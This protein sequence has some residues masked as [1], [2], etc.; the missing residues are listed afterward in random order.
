MMR[1][2]LL[3]LTLAGLASTAAA[4][5]PLDPHAGHVMEQPAKPVQAS[6][7]PHA[8][9]VMP[10][11]Q[12]AHAE[13]A[14]AASADPHAGHRAPPPSAPADPHAGHIMPTQSAAP[15]DPH[16][17]H[18]MPALPPAPVDPH[19]GHAMSPPSPARTGVDLPI[20]NGAPPPVIVDNLADQT[21]GS[22][23]MQRARATLE[24]EH[25]GSPISKVQADLLE[26][27]PDGERYGWEVE[28]W[29]GG[30]INRLAIKTEG[31]G[32]SREGVEGAEVQLLYSRAVSRYTDVQ[33]GLRY[34][35]EPRSRTYATL[36]VDTMLP[37]WFEV[38]GAVFLSSKGDVLARVEGSYDWRLT[39]RLILQPRAELELAAQD[40]PESDIGSGLSTGE[41][42]LRLRYEIR[43]EFAPYIGVAYER[44]FGETGRLARAHGEAVDSTRFIVGLRAWF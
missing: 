32:V 37:Y 19:A 18:T 16:A 28:G 4:Q 39:Q 15:A 44:A 1:A 25:G 43:R 10:A 11:P 31:E 34:D 22:G 40:I 36:A 2:S 5:A 21:F 17:G 14:P 6:A 13:P 3:V 30:D 20:G 12:A 26:W 27:A 24:N 9:H 35:L 29:Y 38:E 33:V 23:P 7:D 8:G 41:F 42:G